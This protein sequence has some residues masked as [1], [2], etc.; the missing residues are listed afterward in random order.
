M[1]SAEISENKQKIMKIIEINENVRNHRKS[2][3]FTE[4]IRK[5]PI[6]K[7]TVLG[8]FITGPISLGIRLGFEVFCIARGGG[9]MRGSFLGN[10]GPRD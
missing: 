6:S 7:K 3:K 9:S 5:S 1:K 4:Q 2:P 8:Q 10:K